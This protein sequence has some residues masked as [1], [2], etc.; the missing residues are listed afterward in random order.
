MS[1]DKTT[2]SKR[3]S[4]K[5]VDEPTAAKPKKAAATSKAASKTPAASKQTVAA[6]ASEPAQPKKAKADAKAVT[7]KPVSAAANPK[8]S[9][10]TAKTP[11]TEKAAAAE[12]PKPKPKAA[13][14]KVQAKLQPDRPV[15]PSAEE[16]RRWVET[17]AY[18]RWEKRGFAP[19]FEE[20]D[21]HAAEAEIDALIGKAEDH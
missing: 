14:K 9:A 17:A 11:V 6:V 10:S 21:W 1:E 16:R 8:K 4:K 18:H 19:G 5:P 3:T 13:A 15:P 7:P 20:E 2:T 12:M